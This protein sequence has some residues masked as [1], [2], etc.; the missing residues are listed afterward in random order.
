MY[1]G[2]PRYQRYICRS[3]VAATLT[4]SSLIS[5]YA[6]T[7]KAQAQTA[8]YC[9]FSKDAI[10][11][12]ESLRINALKGNPD[13]D[14]RYKALLKQHADS[15][16]Q[17][18]SRTW[19]K[20]QAV[21]LRVYPCDARS[22][23]I[24][25]ILDRIVNRGYNKVYL[26]VF[27][28]GQVLLPSADNPTPWLS[29][30]RSPGTEQVDLLAQ[31]IQ[32]GHERGLQVY[33]W[34]FT[35]NFGY[36]YAQR[37][38]RKGVLARNGRGETSLS[39][40]RDQS[41]V[42]IDPYNNQ[43]KTDYYQ[44]VQ[45]VLKRRPDGI[46]FDYIR[47]PRGSGADSV[48]TKL[49]DL[50][51]YGDASKQALYNRSLNNQG[52]ELIQRYIRNGSISASDVKAVQDLYPTEGAPLWQGRTPS[53]NETVA[54]LNWQLW[55]LS[56]AHAAQGVLD[57]LAVATLPAQRAGVT[58]GA[59]FFPD[60]NQ[61]VGQG[62]YDSRLQP[63]DHFS[64][65]LEWHPMSYGVCGHTGCIENLVKRVTDRA[66]PSTPVIPALAGTWGKSVSNRPSLEAQMQ[67]LRQ[68]TPRINGVS[69][70]AYSWQ[71]PE[72]DRDRKFCRLD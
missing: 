54:S 67:A 52:R 8:A 59:V 2:F 4:S 41:Q 6:L 70:F 22:G 49:E 48:A 61:V 44:L 26:E 47:Y 60:A 71:D 1:N 65:S 50:W 29:A 36:T 20:D 53:E 46:L 45:A 63:W 68:K 15:L 64:P 18:R 12:K 37:L 57:F 5:P 27:F 39:F 17:C 40:V 42:F 43:A 11:Q 7:Q 19:P 31:T 14:N 56:V 51:I 28:D 35:M 9:H 3:V 33:A 21:W 10:A 62:G 55:Q 69:H 24:D 58:A 16:R 32:K 38:D 66:D 72:F 34:M 30:L 23:G 25:E 13:S